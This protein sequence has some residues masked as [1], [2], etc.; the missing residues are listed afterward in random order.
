MLLRETIESKPI[1]I[2]NEGLPKGVIARVT[3]PVMVFDKVNANQRIYERAVAECVLADEGVRTKLKERNLFG[4]SEHPEY[5]NIKLNSNTTS[6]VISKMWIDESRSALMADFDILPTI[7]GKFIHVLLEAGCLVGTSSRAEGDLEECVNES[8]EKY[9]RVVPESYRFSCSDF[10]GDRSTQDSL[11]ENYVSVVK[12]QYEAKLLNREDAVALLENVKGSKAKNLCEHIIND[13][14]H[15]GC[16]CSIDEKECT[17][18]CH[19]SDEAYGGKFPNTKHNKV[20]PID[21]SESEFSDEKHE[22]ARFAK[23]YVKVHNPMDVKKEC[24]DVKD[25]EKHLGKEASDKIKAEVDKEYKKEKGLEETKAMDTKKVVEGVDKEAVKKTLTDSGYDNIMDQ[26]MVD[27]EVLHPEIKDTSS[28]SAELLKYLE[29]LKKPAKVGEAKVTERGDTADPE[30]V[31]DAVKSRLATDHEADFEGSLW[32][33]S[34]E[35]LADLVASEEF[36]G[37]SPREQEI[38]H[39]VRRR[40]QLGEAVAPKSFYKMKDNSVVYISEIAENAI[41]AVKENGEEVSYPAGEFEAGV[42]SGDIKV[43]ES[44]QIHLA[45]AENVTANELAKKTAPSQ[46]LREMR[47]IMVKEA[48]ARAEFETYKEMSEQKYR[49]LHESYVTDVVGF[50]HKDTIIRDLES[51][52]RQLKESEERSL[53]ALSARIKEIEAK[54]S[55]LEGILAD[56]TKALDSEGKRVKELLGDVGKKDTELKAK[57]AELVGVKESLNK[58]SADLINKDKAHNRAMIEKY[59][60]VTVKSSGLKLNEASLT[61]LGDCASEAEVDSKLTE[62]RRK[63]SEGLLHFSG[64]QRVEVVESKKDDPNSL[65]SRVK[66]VAKG[67]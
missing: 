18:K 32:K 19:R 7:A 14:Q 15:E 41:K 1:N 64:L 27:F 37:Y 49:G 61:L 55:E 30:Q 16:K 26:V 13:K 22:T 4:D 38:V 23:D 8:K 62:I 34:K 59:A 50:A 33:Q 67:I 57:E 46:V 3:Y 42:T 45:L 54:K 35:E 48:V 11:P 56:V 28:Y 53:A 66:R 20:N 5:V 21:S 47:S 24:V 65:I 25:A 40:K 6:H 44:T 51:R 63:L 43:V 9:F 12:S 10:T 29:G 60:E 36:K 2:V 58:L 39:I 17:G 52:V 31:P